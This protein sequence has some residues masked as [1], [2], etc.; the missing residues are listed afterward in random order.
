[1]KLF[2]L[3]I[4]AGAMVATVGCTT[5]KGWFNDAPVT[6]EQEKKFAKRNTGIQVSE[7]FQNPK[8]SN[9]FVI[10]KNIKKAPNSDT[11][12]S[13][14]M[15]LVILEKSWVNEDDPHKAKIMV[16]KPDL[17]ADF[18]AFIKTGIESY[19]GHVDVNI[20]PVS[21]S[22]FK[23]TY[24]TTEEKGF[25]FWKSLKEIEAV[26]M[27][28]NVNLLEHGR[29]GEIFIDVLDY[30]V[31]NSPSYPLPNAQIR[32]EAIAAHV[33][34]DFMLELDYQYR[35]QVK[36]EQS[37]LEVTLAVAKNSSDIPVLAS[38]QDISYVFSQMEDILEQLGF[39][40]KDEDKLLHT[41]TA[42]Y[43]KGK[44]STWD[45][46]FNSN[47]ANKLDIPT[48]EYVIEMTTSVNGVYIK[49]SSKDGNVFTE[50]EVQ[51]VFELIM[52]IITE[53]EL[54]L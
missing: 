39:D 21:E 40:I 29:S 7:E 20:K 14:T 22:Q 32:K 47:V 53:E 5:M 33:L 4:I 15:V 35:V 25:W 26:E 12:T 43:T 13:P 6:A 19:A 41:Y 45:S 2:K 50:Q 38:Q 8:K 49:F 37:E 34:N 31:T 42:K 44:Q 46:I 11:V 17:V 54:E 1:M 3:A 51:Q 23:I 36:K 52:I 27:M 16:E 9:E 30:K 48:G 10:P 18:P 28:L 24:K